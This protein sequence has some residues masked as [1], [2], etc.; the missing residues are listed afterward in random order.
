[1][2][3]DGVVFLAA[4]TARSLAYAQAMEK[5]GI[6]VE[7]TI[8]FDKASDTQPGKTTGNI[9]SNIGWTDVFI[10]D[11]SIPLLE[12]CNKLSP[13]LQQINAGNINDEEILSSLAAMKDKLKLIIFSGFGG[14]IVRSGLLDLGVPL[15]HIHAGWLPEYRGSTTIYYSL[16]KNEARCGVSAILLAKEIDQGPIVSRR[17]YPLPP[18]G[19]NMDYIYDSA[20]RADLLVRVLKQWEEQKGFNELLA[21]DPSQ[22]NAYYVIHPV[23]KHIAM[24][25]IGRQ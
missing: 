7:T 10:P 5:Q 23:L 24:M 18:P 13:T 6:Q 20:I 8:Y 21:Q 25:S 9:S 16:L 11:L 14:Q 19:A 3:L 4:N 1:M 17:Q 15:L 2:M 22:G 12:T